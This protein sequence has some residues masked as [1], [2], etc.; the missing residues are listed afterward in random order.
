MVE[1]DSRVTLGLNSSSQQIFIGHLLNAWA[2]PILSTGDAGVD[3]IVPC[4]QDFAFY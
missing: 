4:P 3:K 2:P 1:T